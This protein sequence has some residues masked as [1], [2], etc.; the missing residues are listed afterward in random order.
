[1]KNIALTLIF[2]MMSLL[3]GCFETVAPY[4][5]FSERLT[6]S[7]LRSRWLPHFES[8]ITT[9]KKVEENLG[10]PS[11]IFENGRIYIYRFVINEWGKGLDEA[12]YRAY[13]NLYKNR[14]EILKSQ[15]DQRV[16]HLDKEGI[17]LV[18]YK[19]NME[20]FEKEII[21]SMC[22]F[23]LVLVFTSDGILKND[24]LIRIRP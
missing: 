1:M 5:Y 18:V 22:E 17:R 13:Y 15:A 24:S 23:H 20:R 10:Q 2:L 19:E 14:S 9:R 4:T 8:G 3:S 6:E 16:E 21:A 12:D 11:S 7:Y